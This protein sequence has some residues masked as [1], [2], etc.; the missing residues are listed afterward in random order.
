MP[1]IKASTNDNTNLFL[2]DGL[3][4]NR[5]AFILYYDSVE[6]NSSGVIDETKIRIG[7]RSKYRENEILITPQLRKYWSNGVT[8]F[9]NTSATGT[10]TS[11]SPV[12]N[13]FA[14]GTVT[15]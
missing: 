1:I 4:Q 11:A 15:L 5:G 2:L 6:K 10:V 7:L 12:A 13:T 8:I 14:T 9:G 3:D